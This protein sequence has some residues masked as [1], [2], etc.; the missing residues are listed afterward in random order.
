VT[1]GSATYLFTANGA[2]AEKQAYLY[3]KADGNSR[4]NCSGFESDNNS[5]CYAVRCV[6]VNCVKGFTKFGAFS[7]LAQDC[8]DD[9][10]SQC[11]AFYCVADNCD[12]GYEGPTAIADCC[13]AFNCT[14]EG[15]GSTGSGYRMKFCD[16]TS[17]GN[18]SHG[19]AD[20]TGSLSG[21]SYVNCVSVGNGG[22]GF[23]VIDSSVLV[24]CAT[25]NNTSGRTS[26]TPLVDSGSIALTGDPFEDSASEDFKPNDTSGAGALLRGAITGLPGQEIN[27]DIGAVQHADPAGGGG[28]VSRRLAKIIG[29]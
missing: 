13:L 16:C 4:A 6:A 25:Y 22:Y 10:F 11:D 17:Y 9:G 24:N 7:C 23:S 1:F 15:F 19:F 12:R 3:M 29:A 8:S 2:D 28:G 14:N 27:Q 18:G 21:A 5:N 20:R 26:L